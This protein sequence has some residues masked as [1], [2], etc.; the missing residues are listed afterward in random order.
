M[1]QHLIKRFCTARDGVSAVEFALV[2][3]VL[4]FSLLGVVDVGRIVYQRADMET[5]LR[6]GI[7]YFMNGGDDMTKAE[8]VVNQSGSTKPGTT[9]VVADQYCL[10]GG[11]AHACNT[12]CDD[13]TYPVSYS[14][15]TATATL[16]SILQGWSYDIEQTVRV[17]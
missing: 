3:P 13:D 5:A 2:A 17:R 7:Q 14:R 11:A 16:E 6:A 12:I 10:C 4:L 8:D 1:M 9:S 15:I